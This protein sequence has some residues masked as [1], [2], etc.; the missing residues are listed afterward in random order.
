MK[1]KKNIN[2]DK[3]RNWTFI[4]YPES[5]PEDWKEYLTGTGLK[6]AISPLH[7]KDINPTGE[8]K[9]EHYH[10]LVIFDGP[11]TYG[12]VEKITKRL[13]G[14]IPQRVMC[15]TGM[16]R[17]F[18]H[19]DNPEKAQ[20]DEREIITFGGLDPTDIDAL[21]EN[22]IDELINAIL[23][24]I[25]IESINEY[26]KLIDYL[27]KENLKDMFRIARKNTIFF[28]SYLKSKKNVDVMELT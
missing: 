3:E 4:I 12:R 14:T 1:K 19:K 11:T 7:D 16:L 22:Q 13:N 26:S 25:K 21:T 23:I 6:I 9:K 10:V 27:K 8:K 2:E 20:Y 28:N 17:Y 5:L 18:S 15:A 24:I